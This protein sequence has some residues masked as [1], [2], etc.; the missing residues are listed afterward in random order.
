[1]GEKYKF[2]IYNQVKEDA[3]NLIGFTEERDRKLFEKLL[4]VKVLASVETWCPFAR[5]F[6][7][8][9][10]KINEI[11]NIFD[12]SLLTYGRVLEKWQGI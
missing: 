1:M 11:N 8:T 10:K 7:T 9:M 12:L 2:F 4:K 6:L 3:N 5:V